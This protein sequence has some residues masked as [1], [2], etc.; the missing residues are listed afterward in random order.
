MK[1]NTARSHRSNVRMFVATLL[2]YV[3]LT[4]QMAPLALAFGSSEVRRQSLSSTESVRERSDAT[5]DFAPMPA[6]LRVNSAAVAP[7]ISATKVDSFADADGDGKAEPGE[8]ITYSITITNT[9]DQPATNLTLND[10]VDPVNQNLTLIGGSAHST[11][12]AL[13]DA[14]NV[15]GNVRISVPDGGSDLLGNDTDPE[16][17]GNANT[18]LTV[19]TLAGDNS[20]PFSG[21]SANGGQVTAASGNGSFQY[22]PPAG[23]NGTDTFTY[24]TTDGTGGGTSTATVT[25]TITG[26]IWFI[27]SAAA[28]GGNGRLTTPFNCYT[29]TTGGG[30]TCFSDTAADQTG[31]IIFLF[32]G[33]YTGGF[34]LLNNQRV[35]GQG[36]TDSLANIATNLGITVPTFSDALPTTG[37]ASPVVTTSIAATNA[38]PLGQGNLLRG[39]TIGNTTGA[40]ISGNT[41]GTLTVGNNTSPDMVLSGTG[42]ALNLTSG[43]FDATSAFTSVETTSSTAQGVF[44]SQIA[45]TVAFGST[46]VSGSTTQGIAIVQSTANVNF[47]NTTVG[48]GLAGSGG[49]N[50]VLLQNNSGGTRTFGNLTIQNING[51]STSAFLSNTGGGGTGGGNTV[52]GT[53]NVSGVAGTGHGIDIQGLSTLTSVSFGNTTVNKASPGNLVNLGGVGTGNVGTVTFLSLGGTNTNGGGLVGVDNTGALTVTN[54][55]GS[56]TTTLGPAVNI[57]KGVAP[58]SP[59]TLNFTALSSTNSGVQG[60]NLDRVSGNLTTGTTT[61]TNSTNTAIQVQNTGAGTINFGT[62]SA[63]GSGNANVDGPGTGVFLNANTGNVSFG[64]LDVTPD[65]NERAF[66]ATNNTGA[67][68]SASGDIAATGNIALEILGPAGRTPLAM[69][70]NNLDSTNSTGVGVG[71]NLVSGSFTVN[72][73]TL[74]TN[75]V[76]PTGVGLQVT[77]T[78]AGGT[79]NFGRTVISGSGNTG[80]QL[81]TAGNGNA[82]NITFADLDISPDANV[83]AFTAV[84][85]SGTLTTTS[86]DIAATG[87]VTLEILGPAGRTPL[88]MTLNNLDSTNSSGAGVNIN[89]VSGNFTVNDATLATNIVNPT[90]V[91]LQVTNTAAGGTMSFGNTVISGSGGIG[92]SIGTAGNGNAGAIT[93]ADLDISP[94]A[95]IRAFVAIDNTGTLTVATGDITTS[96]PG[97][98]AVEIDGPAGRTPINIQFSAITTAGA[99]NSISLVEVSGTKFQVT[100]TTQIDTRAGTGI[101]VDNSTAASIQFATTN[102][103]NVNNAGGYGIRVEDSSS[104]VTV[105]TATINNAN[106]VTAQSDGD[107]NGIPD[108]DGDGDAIFITNNTGTFTLNGGTLSNCGND[109]IDLRNSPAPALSGVSISLPGIDIP[110][111]VATGA[112][113]G[114]HGISAINITGTNTVNNVTISSVNVGNRDGFY[115]VNT[116]STALTLTVQN[117]TFQNFTGNRGFSI[118]GNAAANMTVTVSSCTFSNI[119]AVALQHTA[120]GSTGSTATVNMT[121]QNSTFQNAPL[122]GKT[123]LLAGV[124]EAGKATLTIQNNTFNNVF[125][126]ASTGEAVL[127]IGQDGTLAGNS[128]TLNISGNTINEVGSAN[129]NCGGGGVTPC[130]GP[131]WAMIVFIDDAANVPGTLNIDNNTITNVRQG[132]INLDMA[133]SGAAASNVAAKVTN[134]CIGRLRVAGACTGAE[135]RI[136]QGA[137]LAAGRGISVERRRIGAKTA[138]VLVSGNTI[139]TGVGQSAGALNTPGIF[140]RTHADT[141]MSLTITNNSI[142]TNFVGAPD[143]RLDTNSPTVGDPATQIMCSDI[144]GNS[145]PNAGPV[146]DINEVVGTH[147]VE[148]TS[149]A[150]VQTLNGGAGTTVTAD[151]GVTFSVACAAPPAATEPGGSLKGKSNQSSAPIAE[152]QVEQ[153]AA[154][155]QTV[156]VADSSSITSQPF[157]SSPQPEAAKATTST[158]IESTATQPQLALAQPAPEQPVVAP[159]TTTTNSEQGPKQQVRPDKKVDLPNPT[160]PVIVGNNL[161]WNVGTLPAGQS[162]T[163]TFQ[164]QVEGPPYTGPAQV[165][166]QGTVTADGGISVQTDDPSEIGPANP[167]VTPIDIPPD[168]SISNAKVAEP[169]SGTTSMLFTVA[170]STPATGTINITYNTADVSEVAPGDYAS[171][172]GGLVTFSA[173]EQLKMIPIT[174]NSD[175]DG[176]EGDETFTVTISVPPAQ[177]NLVGAIGTGTITAANPAGTL[178][179]SEVRTSGPGGS[180]DEFVEIYNNSDTPHVVAA[181]NG[182]DGYGVFKMGASCNATPILVGTIPNSTTIPARGHFLL[183]GSTYSLANYGGTGAAAGNGTGLTSD[184]ENDRNVSLFSTKNI[185]ALNTTTRFDAVGFGTNTGNICDLQREGTNLGNLLGSTLQYSFFRKECDFVLGTGCTIPGRPKDTNDNTADF[186]FADTAATLVA[187]AG[188][189]LGAPGPQNLASPLK[190]DS[191]ISV[192]I[193]DPSVPSTSPPNRTFDGTSDPINNSTF[194][195]VTVRR[196]VV[197]NTGGNVTK[198][199]FRVV[200][201]TTAP[202]PVGIADVRGRNS[203]TQVGIGPVN[204]A[205]T[206]AAT[207]SPATPPCTVTVQGLTLEQPPNQTMGGGYN[208]TLAVGTIAVGTPLAN[209]ASVNIQIL[210]GIQQ[211]GNF[212]FLIIVE[213]LP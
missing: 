174:V 115:L 163:I 91:G 35:V 147:N 104:P 56:I 94:D 102:I 159:S 53:T 16:N 77:N 109:C 96:G 170:L 135:S 21:T 84:D 110:L 34:T 101:F 145:F 88:A 106:V 187:G 150:N 134:N 63:Q 144:N 151:A 13:N 142:D 79:M 141:Q 204:D 127:G 57:T 129:S 64:D 166:N 83:R 172:T 194:G 161:T 164:A 74:A 198:L 78:A 203:V 202:P 175:A 210:L 119:S 41:F 199:R 167:T 26:R 157:V 123:N 93:F 31:D 158:P 103:P 12:I 32:S 62:T 80:A 182:S 148:Q 25:L 39:F 154:V 7:I 68:S 190:R 195:T 51:P 48:T 61:V 133:N 15:L 70:L 152:T 23:F 54:N 189:H 75:I 196:R 188:Q 185:L 192:L 137:G 98:R 9:G 58:A 116:T 113:F 193:L 168:V 43:T 87:N 117:S 181:T 179:I 207:G 44:L 201:L 114:G 20:A 149:A 211:L 183:V 10:T 30:Q 155:A 184:I 205:A 112:G 111:P 37:G 42:Q 126:T 191:T 160:P 89:L 178:L 180:A 33:N 97:N 200:E 71:I 209:G 76:N 107:G 206:C 38:V 169:T 4:S 72:D 165:S 125:E 130:L 140:G 131:I 81:G 108:T 153:P 52:A 19:T 132:G 50:A 2:S 95:N 105:A 121:V 6:P 36:A 85:N 90:G 17:A 197:N 86:G 136:G 65:A 171:V 173:G 40:K 69:T 18:G 47:G 213:A 156:A 118:Q 14:Y 22:D 100:G 120:G 45:G 49:T 176:S 29:G 24:T 92:A 59:I 3:L 73:A 146:I 177:A 138:N 82:A 46:A 208:S 67:I 139:R 143:I 60:V 55:A 5:A 128:L 8:I 122:N 28:A 212:R 186:L 27:N 11:P 162:V 66:H 1:Y 99:S 124:V